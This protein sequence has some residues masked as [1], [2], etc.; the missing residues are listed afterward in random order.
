M[1]SRFSSVSLAVVLSLA[2]AA[3]ALAAE[4]NRPT[5]ASQL[6]SNPADLKDF[7]R[8]ESGF[9]NRVFIQT[10]GSTESYFTSQYPYRD[11]KSGGK[12]TPAA[13]LL[14][15][16]K[17]LL[18]ESRRGSG[19]DDNRSAS[20][21]SFRSAYAAVRTNLKPRRL[22]ARPNNVVLPSGKKPPDQTGR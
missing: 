22:A 17:A 2:S 9:D 3:P 12:A 5:P 15:N 21:G 20:T 7:A 11:F 18:A 1:M 8:K 13:A 4:T 19:L 14:S 6:L 10:P 16:P